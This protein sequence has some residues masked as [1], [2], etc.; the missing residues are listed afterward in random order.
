MPDGKSISINPLASQ[1]ILQVKS[2]INDLKHGPAV[3]PPPEHLLVDGEELADDDKSLAEYGFYPGKFIDYHVEL[4]MAHHPPVSFR[5]LAAQRR[6]AE[7]IGESQSRKDVPASTLAHPPADLDQWVMMNSLAHSA[8]IPSHPSR[9]SRPSRPSG[10][11]ES[12]GPIPDDFLIIPDEHGQHYRDPQGRFVLE[13]QWVGGG[14]FLG[15]MKRL[16]TWG[17]IVYA[18]TRHPWDP[19]RVFQIQALGFR[20]DWILMPVRGQ[21]IG[22]IDQDGERH[23]FGRCEYLSGEVYVGDWAHGQRHGWGVQSSADGRR[24]EGVWIQGDLGEHDLK[25]SPTDCDQRDRLG[26]TTCELPFLTR[27]RRST[28]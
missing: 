20:A 16:N 4:Q 3:G 14:L 18:D 19:F 2:E 25:I 6:P 21:Y 26:L 5:P 23:G 9:P 27:R 15:V 12:N 17:S 10:R 11:I 13:G 7:T 28:S 1:T 24:V 8:A 22:Q